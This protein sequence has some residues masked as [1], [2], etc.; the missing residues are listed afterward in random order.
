[1]TDAPTLIGVAAG[2]IALGAGAIKLAQMVLKKGKTDSGG[3]DVSFWIAE[4]QEVKDKIQGVKEAVA[5]GEIDRA[6][7]EGAVEAVQ[8]TVDRIEQ[9]INSRRR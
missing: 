3:Q 4:F 5:K 6:Q 7:I 8:H 2:A 9:K 1:M